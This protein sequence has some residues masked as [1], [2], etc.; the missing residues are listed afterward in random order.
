MTRMPLLLVLAGMLVMTGA[1]EVFG[2]DVPAVFV[3]GLRSDSRT[4]VGASQRL[5]TRLAIKPHLPN[6][7]STS[8]YETQAQNLQGQLGWLPGKAIA[9][10]HSNGGVVSRQ[11]STIHPL[12]GIV[13]IGTPHSGAPLLYNLGALVDFN[14]QGINLVGITFGLFSP[15]GPFWN[16]FV[17]AQAALQF[18]AD[19][20][21]TSLAELFATIGYQ[22][23]LAAPVMGQMQPGSSY[24]I[25]LNSVPNLMR[26]ATQIPH[27]VGIANI[28][29]R[30]WLGGP[31]RAF[32]PDLADVAGPVIAVAAGY[33]SAR[34]T[35]IFI[36]APAG[37]LD[38]MRKGFALVN[39]AGWLWQVDAFWCLAV[40]SPYM[41][42][43]EANDGLLP[44]SAQLY[45]G[46]INLDASG[47]AHVQETDR[48]DAI[49]EY[50]LTTHTGI[51][52]RG[53]G[54]GSTPGPGPGPG[55]PDTLSPGQR[56]WPGQYVDSADGR[57]RFTYQHD[58]NLVLYGPGA[59]LWATMTSGAGHAEMQVDGNL[60][61]YDD[62]GGAP[63]ASGTD[64]NAGAYLKVQ[65]DGNVVVYRSDGFPLWSTG[66]SGR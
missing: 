38:A 50:A 56:L 25:G 35:D 20:G 19:V 64:G 52:R 43:C 36:S 21:W 41:D 10:G 5:A 58:G 48:S 16:V 66:T 34:G 2:Q 11:W 63:W 3:H 24:L 28:A 31:V 53:S 39:V 4:W 61:V 55:G 54:S 12:R 14:H 33:L 49:L 60:V 51:R 40:S 46:A 30:W 23:G 27:R 22:H 57:F 18:A 62:A 15:S 7:P 65:T 9:V 59:A 26:E 44:R 37:D 32:N 13:T 6:L 29:D 47:P 1:A 45:P 42:R 8:P 17:A